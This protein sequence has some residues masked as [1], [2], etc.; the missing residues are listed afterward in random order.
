M[1]NLIPRF[2]SDSLSG[3][4]KTPEGSLS[5]A[6]MYVDIA[7]FTGITEE[8]MRKGRHGAEEL[9]EL[10]NR[11]YGPLTRTIHDGGGFISTFA[12]DGVTAVFPGDSWP[13]AM[14]A[15]ETIQDSF[16][17]RSGYYGKYSSGMA[18]NARIGLSYG[19]VSWKV[20]GD[21]PR[22][23][24]FYG[25]P[26]KGS[27]DATR[28]RMAGEISL[29]SSMAEK[30]N[31][32]GGAV[33]DSPRKGRGR[34]GR[35]R[36]AI[37]GQ[38]YPE[39]LLK[40]DFGGEFRNV[41][42]MF[43]GIRWDGNEEIDP[44]VE[45]VLSRT[46]DYGGY[47]NG[48]F[49]DEKGP[50]ALVVFGAPVS[51]ENN[52]ERALDLARALRDRHPGSLKTGITQG[53]VYAGFV[54]S[55][56]RCSYTVLGDSVNL[57]ARLMENAEW[58][59]VLVPEG[60]AKAA[61]GE[62]SAD[63]PFEI[64]VK[65]RSRPVRVC[66][67]GSFGGGSRRTVFEGSMVGRE[68]ET[69]A[70]R[71]LLEPMR[72]GRFAGVIYVYGEAGIGKSRLVSDLASGM[73]GASTYV[74]QTDEVLRRGLNPFAYLLKDFFGQA[75]S[76]DRFIFGAR[77]DRLMESLA[78]HPD[79]ERSSSLAAELKRTRSFLA[80]LTENCEEGSLYFQ[81]DAR[82]RFDNTVLGLK[83][84][85]KALSL[86][87]PSIF[88]LEDLQWLDGESGAV[89]K[90]LTQNVEDYPFA[91]IAPSRPE[92][93][94]TKP[95]LALDE[96][97]PVSEIML[98]A[99]EGEPE[100]DLV[101][102]RLEREPSA[103]LLRFIMD[104]TEGNPFYIEQF[105]LYLR[106]QD[107]LEESDGRL[108]LAERDPDI[109]QSVNAVI[110][111]RLDRLSMR[112]RQLVQT[113][114]VLGR[115][116]DVKVLST[117]LRSDAAGLQRLLREGS[118]EAIWSALSEII[119]I[120]RHALLRD[121][122][123]DMQLRRQLQELHA[124]AA[125]AM[126]EL[127]PGVSSRYADIAYHYEKAGIRDRTLEYLLKAARFAEREYRNEEAVDLLKR[128]A[129][130]QDDTEA[131]IRTEL[132]MVQIL[133]MLGRWEEAEE[134]ILRDLALAVEKG[135]R[136]SQ[137]EC[138]KSRAALKHRRGANQEAIGYLEEAERIFEE[139]DDALSL[140]RMRNVSG[141]INTVLGNF[142][143]AQEDL[144]ES[145]RNAETTENRELMALNISDLGNVYLYR[146]QLEKAEECFVRA[147]ALCEEIGDRRTDANIVNNLAVIEYYRR[148]YGRCRELLDHY[149]EISA[150]VGDR[151]SM[152]Y[153]LG[154]IG[155]LR[156][157]IGEL[158][159]AL[160]YYNRQLALAEELGSDYNRAFA[161]RQI[162]HLHWIRGDYPGAL[163][164]ME[165]GLAIAERTGESRGIALT[166]KEIGKIHFEMGDFEKAAEYIERSMEKSRNTDREVYC[167]GL[168]FMARLAM[169]RGM[170]EAAV[171]RVEELIGIRRDIGEAYPLAD[172]LIDCGEIMHTIG[173]KERAR[174]LVREARGI[175]DSLEDPEKLAHYLKLGEMVLAGTED[176]DAAGKGLL[177]LLEE[178]D[179]G[180]EFAARVYLHL[181]RM[182][183]GD[184]YRDRASELY[185]R[186]YDQVRNSEYREIL[187]ELDRR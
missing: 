47:F 110:V 58:G 132:D 112:L 187:E 143:A 133:V 128:L 83:A 147:R 7:G 106:E 37:A 126:E 53:R 116:F 27:S 120:F 103:G 3:D 44:V 141:N 82:G 74:M 68:R 52:A 15:A 61:R 151:E 89:L 34:P 35:V 115:E 111:A 50:H 26:V 107:L 54:G 177:E 17:R 84:F 12:G 71:E 56:R 77:W 62:E 150:E 21:G 165:K 66:D 137:A 85:F 9:S 40:A 108:H 136:G 92:D 168:F 109:P 88:V 41:A 113:A 117:M 127:F 24:L 171:T 131:R 179:I 102:L 101:R 14:D 160:S 95:S 10:I 99:L 30:L 60:M 138:L 129:A 20:F 173:R 94:G 57:A 185:R 154:N 87:R 162:G 164:S 156:Q 49:F 48:M 159:E 81:L 16:R 96:S 114:S 46:R 72:R 80:A 135:L 69:A 55:G 172:S 157:E 91:I 100:M 33:G 167:D 118:G 36:P 18:V 122:A 170:H 148:N 176:P 75:E 184:G 182:T 64:Q 163:E 123:Y 104:R 51:W 25:E 166:T 67:A 181:W 130:L 59:S 5:A 79:H 29:S 8:M 32:S 175:V 161:F 146:Y 140:A 145:V 11:I 45:S 39:Q 76:A 38:F 186:F 23:Y 169:R 73:H 125:G 93:D 78:A 28:G 183:G 119:Y 142:D 2:I 86:V 153:V 124:M 149:L 31:D 22:T 139:L 65:G 155:V 134:I 105:C 174:E 19:T 6:V 97:V 158:D 4:G 98:R 42:S 63:E 43:T 13:A 144:E 178:Q 90:T 70:L 1:L 180:E 121:V 152:T